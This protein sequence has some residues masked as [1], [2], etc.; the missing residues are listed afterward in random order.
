MQQ[1]ST[2]FKIQGPICNKWENLWPYSEITKIG[3]RIQITALK[4]QTHGHCICFL[5]NKRFYSNTIP[6][7]LFWSLEEV[8]RNLVFSTK[9]I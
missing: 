7:C 4:E 1:Y 6:S 5:M 3:T 9:I 2:N 8:V